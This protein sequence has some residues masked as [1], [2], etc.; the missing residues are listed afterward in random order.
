MRP[1]NTL[2]ITAIAALLL[3]GCTQTPPPVPVS[4]SDAKS[5]YNL[6]LGFA[7]AAGG[8]CTVDNGSVTDHSRLKNPESTL[9]AEQITTSGSYPMTILIHANSFVEP[10]T[11]YTFS[12]DL[13]QDYTDASDFAWTYDLQ[14]DVGPNPAKTV[15]GTLSVS[16]STGTGSLTFN[17]DTYTYSELNSP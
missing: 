14:I 13:T 1:R 8:W 9:F 5:C 16:G 7:R 3:L 4:L 6:L 12:G 15:S 2:A 10:S 17:A 11:G